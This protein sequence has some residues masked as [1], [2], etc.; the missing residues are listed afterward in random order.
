MIRRPPRSTLF[1]YTT[2]F[3]SVG[4]QTLEHHRGALL[5]AHAIR[6]PHD[7][8]GRHEGVLRI[9]TEDRGVG[10]AVPDFGL[11]QDRKSTRLNSSHSQISYAVFCLKK[12]KKNPKIRD[13]GDWSAAQLGEAAQAFLA[14]LPPHLESNPDARTV[15]FVPCSPPAITVALHTTT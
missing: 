1:P 9:R 3:R 6:E 13:Q 12:K 7:A 14:D 15:L 4:R 2:L 5:R 10:N 11:G 8:V